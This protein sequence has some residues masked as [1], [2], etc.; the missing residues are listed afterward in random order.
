MLWRTIKQGPKTECLGEGIQAIL[1]RVVRK[2][3]SKKAIFK[4]RAEASR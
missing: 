1:N 2:N 4:K 3:H